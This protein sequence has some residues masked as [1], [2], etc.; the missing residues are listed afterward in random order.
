M[1]DAIKVFVDHG[2]ATL[3]VGRCHHLAR[4]PGQ[5]SVFE[6][7]DAW[8]HRADSFALDPANLPLEGQRIDSS[9]NKSTLLGALR[10]TEPDRWG[11]QLMRRHGDPML[12]DVMGSEA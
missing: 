10:V 4:R 5:S 7:A 8:H 2:G 3:L 9:S 12:C 1:T 11:R 6:Y